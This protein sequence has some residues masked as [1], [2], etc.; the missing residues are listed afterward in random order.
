MDAPAVL[1]NLIALLVI[2]DPPGTAAVFMGLT[3]GA[4]DAERKVLAV[5]AVAIASATLL[6]F[7]VVGDY[8]LS[9]L[10][11]GLPAFQIAGGALL[12][13]LAIDMLFARPSGLRGPTAQE[14]AEAGAAHDISVFPLAI[15]LIAGPGALTT[16]VLLM[17]RAQGSI[18]AIAALL[19]V[20]IAVM[21]ITLALLLISARVV[22]LLGVTGANVISRVLGIV[23]AALAVQLMLDG[24]NAGLTIGRRLA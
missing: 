2:I 23:L 7:A 17:G 10:G 12:F 18:A 3:R 22:R 11:I 9:A 5:R 16:M 14:G 13:L 1:Y 15:P 20:L 6:T 21:A 19:A 8:L 4:T 24:L